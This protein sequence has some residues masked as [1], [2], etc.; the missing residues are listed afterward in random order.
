M[1]QRKQTIFII[2]SIA[3]MLFF[4]SLPYVERVLKGS[5]DHE[6][7]FVK[8]NSLL[9]IFSV[10]T[11]VL[12]AVAIFM[13][14]HL[15]RQYMI[16][17][18]GLVCNLIVVG[19]LTYQII[20]SAEYAEVFKVQVGGFLPSISLLLLLL[21]SRGIIKDFNTLRNSDRLR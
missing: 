17:M 2:L 3:A 9:S 18:I 10:A 15:R 14:K 20:R 13:Y 4:M 6:L 19:M 5:T 8:D 21:A 12:S 11:I 1:I 16:T 7:L